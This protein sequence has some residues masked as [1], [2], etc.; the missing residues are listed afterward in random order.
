[1]NFNIKFV[2]NFCSVMC[3]RKQIMLLLLK[4]KQQAVLISIYFCVGGC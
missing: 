1:M 3:I 4:A 2:M